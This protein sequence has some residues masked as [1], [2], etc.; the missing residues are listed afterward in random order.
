MK[1]VQ[2]LSSAG[3]RI[4]VNQYKKIKKIGGLF[5]LTDLSD[6]VAEVLNMVGMSSMLTERIPDVQE[7]KKMPPNFWK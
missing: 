2:Y 4:L 6:S 5:V 3:I 7:T 1:G